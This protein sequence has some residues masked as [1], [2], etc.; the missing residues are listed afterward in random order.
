MNEKYGILC[1]LL[2]LVASCFFVGCTGQNAGET[3]D[4]SV[5][6]LVYC[7]AGMRE[8]MEEIAQAYTAK[9]GNGINFNFGGSNTL[10]SQMELV[11][12][13]DV[14]MPG[15]TSYFDA[16]QDKG[17]VEESSLVVYHIPVIITPKGNP[18]DIQSLADLGKEG[19]TV[20]LGDAQAAAIGKLSNKILE[21]NQLNGSVYPNVITRSATVNELVLHTALGQVDGAICWEDLV[22]TDEMEV[23]Y[24]PNNQNIIKVVPIGSLTFSEKP[25][26]AQGFVDFVASDE[27]MAIFTK[28]GFT[29]YP[30]DLYADV[31][32]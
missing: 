2:L 32:I 19:V 7:G 30:N 9:T 21:K 10:L 1:V 11:E 24:I 16:A 15:A 28:H 4:E 3:T 27:G 6:L 25:E 5:D 22:N 18:A 20:E 14:Y 13:G 8:P 23:I 29:T 17:F 12:Q 31:I 26:E